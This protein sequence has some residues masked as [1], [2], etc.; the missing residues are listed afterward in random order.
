MHE[1]ITILLYTNEGKGRYIKC[2]LFTKLL[3]TYL[4]IGGRIHFIISGISFISEMFK[5]SNVLTL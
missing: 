1:H 4:V 3:F 5:H 2:S